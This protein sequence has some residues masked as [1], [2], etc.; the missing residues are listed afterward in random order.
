[1]SLLKYL[2]FQNAPF[3][4]IVLF[5]GTLSAFY[6]INSLKFTAEIQNSKLRTVAALN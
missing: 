6:S 1:M 3:L 5:E 4:E 2:Q